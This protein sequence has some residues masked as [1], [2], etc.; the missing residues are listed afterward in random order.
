MQ[1][2]RFVMLERSVHY[3]HKHTKLLKSIVDSVHSAQQEPNHNISILARRELIMTICRKLK[4]Q[5]VLSAQQ[6][7]LVSRKKW[8]TS[9]WVLVLYTIQW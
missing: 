6:E 8:V 9:H 2:V 7:R 3:T 4:R 5:I 1:V